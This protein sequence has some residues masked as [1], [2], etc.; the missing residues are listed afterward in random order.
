MVTL[1][2]FGGLLVLY[3]RPVFG[4]DALTVREHIG[5]FGRFSR[6]P[7][8][9][10]NTQLGFPAGLRRMEFPAIVLHYSLFGS[11]KYPM[12]QAFVDYLDTSRT[13]YKVAF[14][15]DEYYFCPKRFA[16]INEHRI[17]T[18]YTLLEDRHFQDVYGKYTSVTDIVPTLTGYVSDELIAAAKR[19]GRA[20]KDRRIDVGYRG[21]E[22]LPYM[23]RAACEKTQI[24]AAFREHTRDLGLVLDMETKEFRRLYGAD[25][26]RFLGDC[27]GCLGVEA[28]VSVFDLEGAVYAA[29]EKLRTDYPQAGFDEMAARLAP[30][31]DPWEDR[32][33]YRT[34]SPR[35]FEA[36]AFRICQ[37]LYEGRYSGVLEAGRHFIA[38][39]K[40]F[41]NLDDVLQTFRDPAARARITDAAYKDLVASGAYSYRRFVEQFDAHLLARGLSPAPVVG[42]RLAFEVLLCEHRPVALRLR[43]KSLLV[44]T[45]RRGMRKLHTMPFLGEKV[46]LPVLRPTLGW[47]IR[48]Y[49]AR[50][51]RRGV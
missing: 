24:A 34:I 23:G 35:H 19:Y 36:A 9:A 10:V 40:D 45:L 15:Q 3:H 51:Q 13:S 46:L 14:F 32:I 21:R 7:V 18:I 12:E 28:G 29:Y 31:M 41:S 39:K 44:S 42:V 38:L 30:V 4:K 25:W 49:K 1:P 11:A 6:F 5:A 43:L 16:F 37:I 22:L 47:A 27:R 33:F 20:D 26:Y 2:R 48:R 50:L 8:C 17:D